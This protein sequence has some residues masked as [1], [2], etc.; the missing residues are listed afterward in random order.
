MNRRQSFLL[1]RMSPNRSHMPNTWGYKKQVLVLRKKSTVQI[2]QIKLNLNFYLLS[3]IYSVSC[4]LYNKTFIYRWWTEC[5]HRLLPVI[6]K[7]RLIT[8]VRIQDGNKTDPR[9]WHNVIIGSVYKIYIFI[10][11]T[12]SA[13]F[14]I[15]LIGSALKGIKNNREI[16]IDM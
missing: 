8:Y 16:T 6:K 13:L 14:H 7:T 9:K 3:K 2:A 5:N 11:F 15:P 10:I 4:N 12:R 1:D